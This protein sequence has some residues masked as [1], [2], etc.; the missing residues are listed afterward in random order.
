MGFPY[1]TPLPGSN[2]HRDWLIFSIGRLHIQ[3]RAKDTAFPKGCSF[4]FLNPPPGPARF[5]WRQR[6]VILIYNRYEHVINLLVL[7][8][9][10]GLRVTQAFDFSRG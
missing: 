4:S 3:P 5:S 10:F 6:F 7:T 9:P 1:P 2:P 8:G